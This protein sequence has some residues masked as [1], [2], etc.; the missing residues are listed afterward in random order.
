MERFEQARVQAERKAAT[1]RLVDQIAW[2]KELEKTLAA[3]VTRLT[4]ETRSIGK[5]TLNIESYRRE[6]NQSEEVLHKM[7]VQIDAL[8]LEMMAPARVS[9]LE[10]ASVSSL[11]GQRRHLA[12][13]GGTGL[14]AWV[15]V[16]ICV[17]LVE[18]RKGRIDSPDDVVRGL[19]MPVVG[20]LPAYPTRRVF[21]AP[22]KLPNP[23]WK[24]QLTHSVDAVRTML[25]HAARAE[26]LRVI[27]ITSAVTGEGKTSLAG[28]LAASLARAG[29]RTLLVDC[30][31]RRPTIHRLFDTAAAPG[32]AELL[33]GEASLGEAIRT[34]T[35]SV[36]VLPAGCSDGRTFQALAQGGLQGLFRELRD[37]YDFIIIDSSPVLPVADSL[38]IAEEADGVLLSLL[39]DVSQLP[40]LL[41]AHE[42]LEALGTR[43]LGVVVNG[44]R[45]NVYDP[46]YQ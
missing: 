8:N 20:T 27:L 31:L 16:L 44:A 15:L 19:G 6:I 7:G 35:G 1:E 46:A 12:V 23:V 13:A 22:R 29:R 39:R 2:L 38:L 40:Q 14:G 26:R 45:E 37:Q 25:L 5:G 43:I 18:Y 17:G 36:A 30:D 34:A 32:V 10:P 42:R 41:A 9:V 33:R 4:E 3:D 28:H 24:S 11:D 21:G